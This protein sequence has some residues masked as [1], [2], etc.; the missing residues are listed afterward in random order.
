MPK[1]TPAG[2]AIGAAFEVGKGALFGGLTG[3]AGNA[4]LSFFTPATKLGLSFGTYASLGAIA[5]PIMLLPQLIKNFL[6]SKSEYLNKH[7]NLKSVLSDT[8]DTLFYLGA[9]SA[10]TAIMGTPFALTVASLMVIP[11]LL[12][13]LSVY[14]GVVNAVSDGLREKNAEQPRFSA[15]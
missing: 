4:A 10:A 14:C 3:F 6:F 12:L 15:L 1:L 5:T 11:T 9:V 8:L 2:V 7:P 13:A